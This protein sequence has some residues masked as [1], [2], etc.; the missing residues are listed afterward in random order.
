MLFVRLP[1]AR[2]DR[3]VTQA[4]EKLHKRGPL[5]QSILFPE[6]F[7]KQTDEFLKIIQE[8][9]P[10]IAQSVQERLKRF[11]KLLRLR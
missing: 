5:N 11:E 3:V 1:S 7:L 6:D 10:G 9:A 4:S 8:L 2:A